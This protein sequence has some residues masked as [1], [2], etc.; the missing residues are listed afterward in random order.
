MWHTLFGLGCCIPDIYD[1]L[2]SKKALGLFVS[3]SRSHL[4]RLNS[5]DTLRTGVSVWKNHHFLNL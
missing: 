4:Q 3:K 1:S 5:A 2:K